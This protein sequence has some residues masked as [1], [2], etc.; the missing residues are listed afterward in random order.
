MTIRELEEKIETLEKLEENIILNGYGY[1]E[2]TKYTEEDN[3]KITKLKELY[4]KRRSDLINKPLTI[5]DCNRMIAFCIE[6]EEAVLAG[7][8]YEFEGTRLT[9]ANLNDIL[10]LKDYY[11]KE[12]HRLETEELKCIESMEIT[13]KRSNNENIRK[14]SSKIYG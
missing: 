12:K 2:G 14:N 7:Q 6:A 4:Q 3:E 9:R 13:I 10:K 5:E 8:E 1:F 11:I